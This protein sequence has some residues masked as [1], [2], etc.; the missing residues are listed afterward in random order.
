MI[1]FASLDHIMP[2]FKELRRKKTG[3]KAEK[4]SSNGGKSSNESNATMPISKS[5][6]TLNSV[7]GSSTPASSIQP[8]QSTPNLVMSKSASTMTPNPLPQRPVPLGSVSNRGSL[9]VSLTITG[10]GEIRLSDVLAH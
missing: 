8:H 5:S 9:M 4:S 1:S 6:S 2:F 3:H 10:I 7:Y